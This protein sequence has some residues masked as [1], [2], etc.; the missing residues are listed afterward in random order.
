DAKVEAKA[1]DS[2]IEELTT[3]AGHP[4]LR[5]LARDRRQLLDR[6]VEQLRLDLRVADAHVER[7]LRQPRNAHDRAE[8]ELL[9]EP[10]AELIVVALL[11]A[12]AMGCLRCG[13]HYLSISWPQSA[14]LQTRTLIGSSSLRSLI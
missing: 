2:A 9:L 1:L 5:A 3:I 14:R 6:A 4:H 7:D 13:H 8:S 11:Q 10:G 12:R